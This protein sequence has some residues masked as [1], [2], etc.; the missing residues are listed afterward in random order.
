MLIIPDCMLVPVEGDIDIATVPALRHHL[1]KLIDGGCQRIILDMAQTT[2]IDSTGMAL[3]LTTSRSLRSR[4][5]LLSLSNVTQPVMHSLAISRLCDFIPCT[6]ARP[7]HGDVI[8]LP[9]DSMPVSRVTV[10]VRRDRLAEA[11]KRLTQ[12]LDTLPFS[13]EEVFDTVLAAGEAMGNAVDHTDGANVFMTICVYSDRVVVEVTDTGA[14]FELAD[15]EDVP[16]Y[17]ERGRG[18][19]IA[20]MLADKVEIRRRSVGHGTIVTLTKMFKQAAA[21]A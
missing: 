2:Y 7:V 6:Q 15:D 16:T 17:L 8:P 20:R 10:P 12:V 9:S 5:G 11:R 3:I 14:G 13:S 19:K 4:G 21:S 1:D 18:I